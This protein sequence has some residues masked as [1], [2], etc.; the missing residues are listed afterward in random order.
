MLQQEVF[1]SRWSRIRLRAKEADVKFNNLLTHINKES[2]GEAFKALDGSKALGIDGISKKEYGRNL[3]TNIEHLVER[4]HNGSYKP[5]AKREV[6]IPKADGKMR[7][8]AIGCFEDKL[9]EWV[10]SKILEN[11]YEPKFIRN[12]FGFRPKKSA[13]QAIEACYYSLYDN[14]RPHVVEIDFSRFFNTIP[15]GKMMEILGRRISDNRFKGLIGRLMQASIQDEHGK[16][17]PTQVG[18]PQGSIASPILANIY[19]DDMLDQW[20]LENYGSYN[21][22]IVRYAD[23]AVFLF[24]SEKDAVQFVLDLKGRV[25]QYG[26]E[27]NE[28]KTHIVNFRNTE[29]SQFDFLGFTFFW[30]KKRPWQKSGLKVKTQKKQLHK[31]LVEFDH[32]VKKVR[33]Y[34]KI[35]EIWALASAKLTGHYNYFGYWMNRPKL[36]HFYSEAV[37][38]LFRWLNR[39]GQKRSYTWEG[40]KERLRQLPL[41]EPPPINKLRKLGWSPYV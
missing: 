40:F 7:P 3:E 11:I 30:G 20:F 24:H 32:W 33:S 16:L 39:R 8:L 34:N 27:L 9:V 14:K 1:Q 35:G 6:L 17:F 18:T 22:I 21:N 5:Q 36:H 4:I 38:S 31:K 28:D 2:L 19:L 37:G 15:H 10:I 13:H 23:D 29:K 26:L 25:K 12:S 41:P